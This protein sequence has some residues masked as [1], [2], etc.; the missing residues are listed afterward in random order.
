MSR[1]AVAEIELPARATEVEARSLYVTLQGITDERAKRGRRYEA[2]LVLTLMLLA[3]LAGEQTLRG[4]AHWVHLRAAWLQTVLE[5]P[6]ARTPC[7][8]TYR[9]I[10]TPINVDE[11][12]QTLGCFFAQASAATATGA[13]LS[14]TVHATGLPADQRGQEHLCFDGK[15]LRGTCAADAAPAGATCGAAHHTLA[16]YNVT[17]RPVLRQI[18]IDGPGDEQPAGVDLLHRLDLRHC[19]VT[20]D[21]LHTR[22]VLCRQILAQGG[23]YLLLAKQNQPTLYDDIALL[24]SE[25]PAPWLPEHQ[26]HQ[27]NKGHGRIEVRHL[28]ISHELN[29]YLMPHWPAVAQV[30]QLERRVHR[31]QRITVEFRYGLTSLPAAAAPPKRLLQLLRQHWHIENRLHWRRDARLR[32]DA[33]RVRSGR[34]PYALAALNNTVLALMDYLGVHN[35]AAQFRVFAAQPHAALN[36]LLSPL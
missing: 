25:R 13:E 7:P 26:F 6:D 19:V 21:A 15:C 2:A 3:K 31:R 27:V 17:R 14:N 5:L 12:N 23:D 4:I 22:P 10:C 33:C 30:F 18:S 32:E 1:L 16:L 35:V 20:A 8:N 29:D 11:L 28:R 24:F 36:L 34:A 9:Y